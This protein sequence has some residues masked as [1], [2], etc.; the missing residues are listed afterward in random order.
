[1][2]TD[3]DGF[4]V[5]LKAGVPNADTTDPVC[6]ASAPK[7]E[8]APNA[9]VAGAAGVPN[10]ENCWAGAADPNPVCPKADI[11]FGCAEVV[12]VAPDP[13]AEG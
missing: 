9:E 6:C 2:N 13:K 8:G 10:A 11:A 1:M 12:F 7:A 5:V 3:P 4:K